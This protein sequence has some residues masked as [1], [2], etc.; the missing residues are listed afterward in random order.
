MDIE[1]EGSS[2]TGSQR[3]PEKK[4]ENNEYET[5]DFVM[6]EEAPDLTN[7][8][9]NAIDHDPGVGNGLIL[10]HYAKHFWAF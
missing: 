2:S 4:N 9:P 6:Q 3:D 5:D 10:M 7:N 8:F 1:E